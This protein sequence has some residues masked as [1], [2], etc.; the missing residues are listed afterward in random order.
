LLDEQQ[1]LSRGDRERLFGYLEG[2]G[3]M[4]L[5]E[6][7]RAADR[8]SRMPGLDGQKMSK[9]YGNT[10]TLREDADSVTKKIRTMPTDPARVRRTDPGDPENCP[11]WQLH[12]VYSDE[13]TGGLGA[14]RLPQRRHRLPGMQAAG[15]RG[16]LKPSRRRCASAP[17]RIWTIRRWCATSSPTVARRRASWPGDHARSA[18]GH[19]PRLQL[20]WPDSIPRGIFR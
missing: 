10:M 19:G 3:K 14:G 12:Q 17:R 13:S 16:V 1:N 6:P 2:S 18:R 11:V 5:V 15:D 4:I 20:M 8:R 9:S 7:R